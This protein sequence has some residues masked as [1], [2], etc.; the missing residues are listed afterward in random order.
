MHGPAKLLPLIVAA[1]HFDK[2][3][4]PARS[5][6]RYFPLSTA[7]SFAAQFRRADRDAARSPNPSP[8]IGVALLPADGDWLIQSADRRAKAVSILLAWPRRARRGRSVR[9]A[10]RHR[11]LSTAS[12][13][14]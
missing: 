5:G 1:R 8:I 7:R 2:A 13:C 14:V 9:Q 10:R 3:T 4:P 6:F 11:R 12:R